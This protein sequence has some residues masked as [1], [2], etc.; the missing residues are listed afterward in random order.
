MEKVKENVVAL[1]GLFVENWGKVLYFS[2]CSMILFF[3]FSSDVQL[4][5]KIIGSLFPIVFMFFIFVTRHDWDYTPVELT[6][7][8]ILWF[9]MSALILTLIAAESVKMETVKHHPRSIERLDN[10]MLVISNSGRVL[11]SKSIMYYTAKDSDI[12]IV[13]IKNWNDFGV[14]LADTYTVDFCK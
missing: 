6:I 3:W 12:C 14:R 1:F 5:N 11:T 8:N 7:G 9:G 2:V 10:S 4:E 13:Q